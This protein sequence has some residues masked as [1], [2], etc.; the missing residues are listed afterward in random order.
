M[1]HLSEEQPQYSM[2][3]NLLFPIQEYFGPSSKNTKST[4]SIPV[5]LVSELSA[6]RIIKVIGW[7][8][9]IS[10][11]LKQSQWLEKDATFLPM[12][13]SKTNSKY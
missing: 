5:Q 8:S 7:I 12:S 1:D 6:A 10:V 13:G 3:V 4:G 11:P 2:K 9:T